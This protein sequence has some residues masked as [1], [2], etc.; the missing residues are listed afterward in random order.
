MPVSLIFDGFILSVLIF[1]FINVM[2]YPFKVKLFPLIFIP[3]TIIFLVIQMLKDIINAK[4]NGVSEKNSMRLKDLQ[5]KIQSSKDRYFKTI[6]WIIG[7]VAALYLMGFLIVSPIFTTLVLR[8]NG[9][10]WRTSIGVSA[11]F[12]GIFFVIFI[13]GLDVQIYKGFLYVVLFS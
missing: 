3:M 9:E 11:I 8:A 4:K 2:N 7:L 12:W 13:Y 5:T 1:L 6:L 10:R